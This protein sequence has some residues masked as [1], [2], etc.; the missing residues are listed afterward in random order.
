MRN[1]IRLTESELT[2][3][4]KKIIKEDT[5]IPPDA[6]LTKEL[7]NKGFTQDETDKNRFTKSTGGWR[8]NTSGYF[9]I[10]KV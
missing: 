9:S 6:T 7:L 2:K 10:I 1:K 3:I 4:I 5:P 8:R